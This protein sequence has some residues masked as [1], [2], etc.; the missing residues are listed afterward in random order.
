MVMIDPE[1]FK[2]EWFVNMTTDDRYMYLYLLVNASPKTGVFEWNERMINF[3]ANTKTHYTKEDIIEKFGG[4]IVPVP[5]HDS[6]M[7][8][9][10]Y[11]RFNWLKDGRPLNPENNPLH[12]SIMKELTRYGLTVESLNDMAK[13]KISMKQSDPV[14]A[15]EV[16]PDDRDRLFEEFWK[17][18]P[19]PRKT[20][21]RKCRDKFFKITGKDP[22]KAVSMFNKIMAGID[23]WKKTDCWLKDGGKFICA[24]AVWLNNERWDAE[25]EVSK[26]GS[27]RSS[28]AKNLF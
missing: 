22:D 3:C 24:P 17:A 21:K 5:N 26:D 7:I 20:D 14:E 18:Y 16:A 28:E 19:G 12:R 6:T 27:Y 13:H 15:E 9:T 23:R 10:D 11:V 25:V 8:I 4:R 2:S 1:L